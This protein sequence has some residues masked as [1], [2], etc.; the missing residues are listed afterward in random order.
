MDSPSAPADAGKSSWVPL[1]DV[2]ELSVAELVNRDDTP[3]NR[4][5]RQVIESLDDP[6]GVISA[7]QSFSST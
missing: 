3:F 2:S 1:L 5:I 4:M 7:F 6:N